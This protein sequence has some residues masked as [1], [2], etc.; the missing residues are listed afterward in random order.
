MNSAA[1]YV[2]IRTDDGPMAAYRCT[3]HGPARGGILVLHEVFGLTTHMESICQRLAGHGWTALAPALFHRN[4]AP[5]IGYDNPAPGIA[6]MNALTPDGILADLDAAASWF[7]DTGQLGVI[8]FC[9]GGAIALYAA[10]V[11]DF[12]AA[13]TFYGVGLL[14]GQAG[15]PPLVDLAPQIRCP[16]LGLYGALDRAAPPDQVAKLAKAISKAPC[17]T[18][19]VVYENAG[20][21][22]HCDARPDRYNPAAAARAWRRALE[23]FASHLG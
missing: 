8:G 5:V 4:G 6:Q 16:W 15:L 13:V 12:G 7:G 14:K 11:R 1:G 22:F 23:F 19:I 10:A 18:E 9:L 21:A 3:P 17:P 2:S 20:H